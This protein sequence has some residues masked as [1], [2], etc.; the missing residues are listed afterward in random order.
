MCSVN[1][2]SLTA[3][4]TI[5]SDDSSIIRL[6]SS[7]ACAEKSRVESGRDFLINLAS[8]VGSRLHLA[9]SLASIDALANVSTIARAILSLSYSLNDESSNRGSRLFAT[10]SPMAENC[11]SISCCSRVPFTLPLMISIRLSPVATEISSFNQIL[12]TALEIAAPTVSTVSIM[13]GSPLS[14]VVTVK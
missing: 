8:V 7:V 5:Y 10:R 6:Y 13:L 1:L 14:G 3:T 11:R 12:R 4:L 2:G 9:K